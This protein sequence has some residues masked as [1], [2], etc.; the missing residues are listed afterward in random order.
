MLNIS[1][2]CFI[3]KLI[4]IAPEKFHFRFDRQRNIELTTVNALNMMRVFL[5]KEEK[6]QQ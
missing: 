3:K 6:Y 4:K 2:K 1:I 5:L